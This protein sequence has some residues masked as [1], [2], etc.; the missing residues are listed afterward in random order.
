MNGKEQG[1]VFMEKFSQFIHLFF[2]SCQDFLISFA[3]TLRTLD[4]WTNSVSRMKAETPRA[5]SSRAQGSLGLGTIT[6]VV[7]MERVTR[8]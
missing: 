7:S 5:T 8:H 3:S 2:F 6:L 4:W 1:P